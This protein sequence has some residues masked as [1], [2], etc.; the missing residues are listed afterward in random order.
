M[1]FEAANYPQT[2]EFIEFHVV[3]VPPPPAGWEPGLLPLDALRERISNLRAAAL[4]WI[5]ADFERKTRAW[6][7]TP[8]GFSSLSVK[9]AAA[10]AAKYKFSMLWP[11]GPAFGPD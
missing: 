5:D 8:G 2:I 9:D 3:V 10:I 1:R 6:I 11:R 4:H 7:H